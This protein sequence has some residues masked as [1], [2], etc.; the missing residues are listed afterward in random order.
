MTDQPRTIAAPP[1]LTLMFT[2][3]QPR[4]GDDPISFYLA[5]RPANRTGVWSFPSL[6]IVEL[7]AFRALCQEALRVLDATERE[8][9]EGQP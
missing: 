7:A 1:P 3:M 4:N 9:E 8:A 5:D 6:S 2:G